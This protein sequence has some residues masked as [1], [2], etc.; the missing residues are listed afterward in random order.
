MQPIN[1]IL[2]ARDLSIFPLNLCLT[3]KQSQNINVKDWCS[4]FISGFLVAQFFSSKQVLKSSTSKL[5]F[6][7][8]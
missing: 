5:F 8:K 3:T 4:T 6:K 1:L 7:I 2:E